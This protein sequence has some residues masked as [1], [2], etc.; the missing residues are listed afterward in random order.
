MAFDE[1]RQGL[2]SV[3]W[4]SVISGM[5]TAVKFIALMAIVAISSWFLIRNLKFKHTVFIYEKLG[6]GFRLIKDRGRF[7]NNKKGQT[8]QLLRDKARLPIGLVPMD[9]FFPIKALFGFKTAINLYKFGPESYTPLQ[10]TVNEGKVD[11]EPIEQKK[12]LFMQSIADHAEKEKSQGFWAQH[13]QNVILFGCLGMF[14]MLLIFGADTIQ[15]MAATA[16]DAIK[17]SRQVM[18]FMVV[19]AQEMNA[20]SVKPA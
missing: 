7:L 3:E 14:I 11:L 16:G 6:N 13:G 18:E 19:K 20:C 10:P 1:V 2:F 4:G 8:F 17:E 12:N 15:G 9:Y 5:G